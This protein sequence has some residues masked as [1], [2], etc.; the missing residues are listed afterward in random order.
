M[1][2]D[3]VTAKIVQN[4]KAL[5]QENQDWT[6][7]YQVIRCMLPPGRR[8]RF[9]VFTEGSCQGRRQVNS[10]TILELVK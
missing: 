3:E 4:I 6:S 10:A 1:C 9:A 5:R 2:Y 8:D 7:L